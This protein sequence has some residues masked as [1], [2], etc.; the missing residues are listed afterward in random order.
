LTN[1]PD[2]CKKE[3]VTAKSVRRLA[4][5]SSGLGFSF[6]KALFSDSQFAMIKLGA[7]SNFIFCELDTV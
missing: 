1:R 6:F 5:P 7:F 2:I 3:N 4:P